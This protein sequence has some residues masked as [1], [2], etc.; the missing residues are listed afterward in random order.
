MAFGA[1]FYT[2]SKKKNSTK[3]PTGGTTINVD[4]K[5]P[6]TVLTPRLLISRSTS[7]IDYNYCYIPRFNRYYYI[8][9]WTLDH[10]MWIAS[11]SVDVLASYK[12]DIINS[13]QYV[14]RCSTSNDSNIVDH[15]YPITDEISFGKYDFPTRPFLNSS[16]DLRYIIAISNANSNAAVGGC[17][18]Y[19]LTYGEFVTLMSKLLGSSSYLGDFSLDGLSDSLVKALVNPLSYIGECYIL[20]YNLSA[21]YSQAALLNCGWWPV[22]PDNSYGIFKNSALLNR[23]EIWRQ[24]N[25]SLPK[26]PQTLSEGAYINCLPYTHYTVYAGPFGEF[27]LDSTLMENCQRVDFVM[28]GDFKG[29][30]ELEIHGW[31]TSGGVLTEFIIDKKDTNC[32]IPISLTQVN[33][34]PESGLSMGIA[35]GSAGINAI[36]GNVPGLCSD[37]AAG[38]DSAQNYF[39]PKIDGKPSMGSLN[40]ALKNWHIFAEFHHITDTEVNILGKPLCRDVVLNT[41]PGTPY[42]LCS[43]AKLDISAYGPEHD[44]IIGYLNSGMYL[45]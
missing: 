13:G 15:M 37:I 22:D 42:I 17:S 25:I 2:F 6:S 44:E 38:I 12:T 8:T 26:H 27:Q 31:Q 9:D 20:P 18:Y 16:S 40:E 7:P 41:L 32:S 4:I 45:E 29:N 34:K 21:S 1:T 39:L 24:N 23:H 36:S 30:I 14:L 5:E 3:R 19:N 10:N 28:Y 33:N 35:A 43:H 11:L